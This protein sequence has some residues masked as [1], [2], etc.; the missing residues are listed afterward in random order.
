MACELL[1]VPI[2]IVSIIDK[3]REWFK[4]CQGLDIK[5]GPRNT[6]FCGHAMLAKDI[7]II[8]DA[9]QDERFKDNPKVIDKPFIRFYAGY[10]LYDSSG[11]HVLGVFC[12]KD[13]KPRKLS[14]SEIGAFL[15]IAQKVQ[16][17]LNKDI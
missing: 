9:L 6:S 10:A 15:D 4:S 2:A 7:F 14:V 17:E 5:E 16:I 12:I 1:K 13:T 11:S 8:E 3:D